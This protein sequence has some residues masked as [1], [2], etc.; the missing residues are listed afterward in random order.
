M[1][2]PAAARDASS[3]SSEP[4]GLYFEETG[5]GVPILP[6]HPS[7]A[8]SSTWGAAAEEL[9]RVGCVIVYDRRGY[10]RSGGE[11]VRSVSTHTADDAALLEHLRTPPAVV[12]GTSAGAA[13][14]VDLA[15][16]LTCMGRDANADSESLVFHTG[17]NLTFISPTIVLRRHLYPAMAAAG[18][19]RRGPHTRTGRSTAFGT[20]SRNGRSRTVRRSPGSLVTS[21]T[22]R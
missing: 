8:T 6:I 14:A 9:T 13:I 19:H 15:V 4:F 10:A 17:D 21:V 18:V 1:A 5:E 20:H 2:A 11:P 16:L 3:I 22:R 7:G 12:V